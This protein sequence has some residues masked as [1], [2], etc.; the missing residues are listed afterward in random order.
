MQHQIIEEEDITSGIVSNLVHVIGNVNLKRSSARTKLWQLDHNYHCAVIGTCLTMAEVKK[1]LNLVQI[2]FNGKT[3]YDL[4]TAI[5]TLISYNDGRSKKVQ[6]YLDKKFSS[7]IQ[8]S[9]KMDEEQLREQWQSSLNTGDIIG[10]FWAIMSHPLC[11]SDMKR[12]IYGDIHMLSHM[13]GASNRADLKRLNLLEKERKELIKNTSSWETKYQKLDKKFVHLK[14]V[15]EQQDNALTDQINQFNLL[16]ESNDQLISSKSAKERQQLHTQVEKLNNKI[17]FQNNELTKY[18]NKVEKLT[19]LVS[20]LKK[21]MTISE[22]T[23]TEHQEETEFL[24]HLLSQQ[25]EDK[26][27]FQKQG[28]C[29]QCVLYVGGRANLIPHYRDLVEAKAGVFLHHDGGIEKSTQDLPQSLKRADLV[30]FPSDC[31]SHDAYWQIKRLCKKQQKPYQ[32]LKSSGLY[33]LSSGLDQI[34]AKAEVSTM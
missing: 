29:G 8:K 10:I 26:C 33:S 15:K 30:I 24:Q 20:Q 12:I 22:A 27:Q 14:T 6:N 13:S 11:D 28:L 18:H 2:E 4:H 5:V 1:L 32:Y 34:I 21:Q 31:I 16:K 3:T 17:S 19:D 9:R 25:Q 7:A 23:I